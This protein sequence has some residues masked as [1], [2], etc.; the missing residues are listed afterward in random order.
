MDNHCLNCLHNDTKMSYILSSKSYK[1]T[2]VYLKFIG[3]QIRKHL[4]FS[5]CKQKYAL[6]FCKLYFTSNKAEYW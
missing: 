2:N 5:F 1:I 3:R 4:R 6:S